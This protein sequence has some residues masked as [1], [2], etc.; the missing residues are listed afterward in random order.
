ML[1]LRARHTDRGEYQMGK[2][3][4]AKAAKAAE[5]APVAETKPA[6]AVKTPKSTVVD[7]TTYPAKAPTA[8]QARLASW[9]IEKTGVEYSGKELAAFQMGTK[10]A[11]ALYLPFQKSPENVAAREEAASKPKLAAAPKAAKGK[12]PTK[13][14]KDK[15]DVVEE[16]VEADENETAEAVSDEAGE[17]AAEAA[18]EETAAV[19]AEAVKPKRPAAKRTPK[20]STAKK[21][22]F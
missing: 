18:V 14:E 9:L 21:A 6:K 22:P 12:K 8:L 16:G 2:G 20:S 7:Y 5:S 19:E 4:D 11:I 10:L 13:A 15:A 1:I 3:K 17:E